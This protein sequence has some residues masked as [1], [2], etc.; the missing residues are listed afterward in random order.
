MSLSAYEMQRLQNM[1][2]NNEHL[3]ALGIEPLSASAAPPPSRKPR[4][5]IDYGAPVRESLR[6][7]C[8]TGIVYDEDAIFGQML[9]GRSLPRKRRRSIDGTDDA[10]DEDDEAAVEDAEDSEGHE[11]DAEDSDEDDGSYYDDDEAFA[12]VTSVAV[13]DDEGDSSEDEARAEFAPFRAKPDTV[14]EYAAG[15]RLHL[16][17]RST[18]G[19]KGVTYLTTAKI[20]LSRR[21]QVRP[22]ASQSTAASRTSHLAAERLAEL[23]RSARARA[24]LDAA[25]PKDQQEARHR[26]VQDC[27]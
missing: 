17:R 12:G 14:V 15:Q 18:T 11:D 10:D 25:R 22:P 9:Y 20:N 7:P 4:P 6:R 16:S 13:D 24:G 21:Y 23:R 2:R 19:Y 8:A 5:R 26:L 3:R 27:G 1:E